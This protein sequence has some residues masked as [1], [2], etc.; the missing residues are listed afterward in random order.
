[1]ALSETV[2]YMTMLAL[3]VVW[4]VFS[5]VRKKTVLFALAF[6]FWFLLGAMH[7]GVAPSSSVFQFAPSLM[8][9]GLGVLFLLLTVYSVFS[10]VVSNL[11]EKQDV[12]DDVGPV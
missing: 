9:F 3:T 1:M 2:L 6:T 5:I 11:K 7:M 8:Y 4:T 12:E 10:D